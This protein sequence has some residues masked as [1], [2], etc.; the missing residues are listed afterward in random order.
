L[1]ERGIF[2]ST[3]FGKSQDPGLETHQAQSAHKSMGNCAKPLKEAKGAFAPVVC[4]RHEV[5]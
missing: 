5:A 2:E 4:V 3:M 1:M